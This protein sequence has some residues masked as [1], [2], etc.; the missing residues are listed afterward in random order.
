VPGKPSELQKLQFDY[1]WRWFAYH[2]DQRL[3]MFNYMLVVFGIFAVG[4][5]NTLDKH[6]PKV[7][8]VGLSVSA[9]ILAIIFRLLDRRNRDLTW[10]GED[11]LRDLEPTVLFDPNR[12]I[13]DSYGRNVP[14]SILTRPPLPLCKLGF[15]NVLLGKHRTL[16]PLISYLIA[17][18]FAAAAVWIWVCWN[19]EK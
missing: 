17:A 6:L 1:A 4:I 10:L 16:L 11:I 5:V 15:E 12:L 19:P 9:V 14:E 7:I 13:R 2:A 18:L 3:K 8:A